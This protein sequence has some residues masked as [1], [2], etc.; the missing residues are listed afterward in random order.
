MKRKGIFILALGVLWIIT[1]VITFKLHAKLT[2][3]EYQYVNEEDDTLLEIHES[4]SVKQVFSS[5]YDLIKGFSIKISSNADYH[6]SVWNIAMRKVD[7]QEVIYDQ[8]F[9]VQFEDD[10]PYHFFEFDKCIQTEKGKEYL[11]LITPKALDKDSKYEIHADKS[12]SMEITSVKNKLNGT[13][14][15][16]V[17][18][19]DKN[20]WWSGF[21]IFIALIITC[22]IVRVYFLFL[23][24][25]SIKEDRLL[26]ALAVFLMVFILI[27]AFSSGEGYTDELDNMRGGILISKGA[28]LY[29]DYVTQ[30]TPFVYY[31]C[32]LFALFGASSFQQFRL[33]FYII[34][35]TVWAGLYFRHE[36]TIGK[37]R[38]LFLAVAECVIIGSVLESFD[39]YSLI[40]DSVQ[41]LCLIA[42]LLEFVE[43]YSDRTISWLRAMI[44]AASIWV[45]VGSAFISAYAILVVAL[46]VAILKIGWNL[47]QND[48]N[49]QNL[50][51]KYFRLLVCIVIPAV[52]VVVYFAIN[53]SLSI[54]F[55]QF[56]TFNREIYTKYGAVGNN[57]FEP[58]LMA[59]RNYYIVTIKRLFEIVTFQTGLEGIKQFIVI[60]SATAVLVRICLKREWGKAG[61]LFAV[62]IVSASRGYGGMH[63]VAAWNV[64]ILIIALYGEVVP[65]I[66][67]RKMR[68]A[69]CSALALLMLGAYFSGVAKGVLY[70]IRPISENECRVVS[71][72]EPDEKILI[73][74]YHFDYLYLL[75]KNRYPVNRVCYVLPWYSDGYE[76]W[77][78]DDLNN[79][80]P[81]LVLYNPDF[82][83]MDKSV[84][85]Y[86]PAFTNE[87]KKN[88]KRFSDDPD[89]GWLKNVWVRQE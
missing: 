3:L 57:F 32:G 65:F 8:D 41:G 54:A 75:Y 87:L 30:H 17:Y 27:A 85:E 7:D 4:E 73:D 10:V 88:Y 6:K 25:T 35:A 46:A 28:V 62:M 37:K 22:A 61:T 18:G 21:A 69:I 34:V 79:Y 48:N 78:I 2:Y 59:I 56:Y 51:K 15:F 9:Q 72:T 89:S 14:C 66:K 55:D 42:L 60:I 24:G 50:L 29:R 33:L 13:I 19:G 76:Q 26:G 68:I 47:G 38:M 84:A 23:S 80:N 43:F 40:S 36:S 1:A 71:L 83:Y 81:R 86:A 64:A 5:P 53:H 70:R 11:L 44:I 39:G 82:G 52:A 31:L 45:A 49:V 63:S 74:T 12:E 58:F 77:L 16:A 67:S 20:L